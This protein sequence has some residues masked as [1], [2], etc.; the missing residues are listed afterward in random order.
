MREGTLAARR[1]WL[2]PFVAPLRL[3]V[4]GRMSAFPATRLLLTHGPRC[5]F[6]RRTRRGLDAQAPLA[7][8]RG[9]D[10]EVIRTSR[11]FPPA[12]FAS[13][14]AKAIMAPGCLRRFYFDRLSTVYAGLAIGA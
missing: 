9:T 3:N 10:P 13:A 7:T 1:D 4:F 2:R 5:G 8:A 6:P 14:A 12:F 11:I